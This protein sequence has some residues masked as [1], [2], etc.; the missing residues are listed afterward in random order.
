MKNVIWL[1]IVTLTMSA[2]C[3]TNPGLRQE[4]EKVT[5][6]LSQG[7]GKAIGN[8]GL[9]FQPMEDGFEATFQVAEDGTF[10]GEAIPGKYAYYIS[11]SASKNAEQAL[12]KVDSQYREAAM[13]RTVVVEPGKTLSLVLQ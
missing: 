4:S 9:V 8:V 11:K 7:D 5:G 10:Q 12:R 2:G 6:K 3:S 13:N 1:L